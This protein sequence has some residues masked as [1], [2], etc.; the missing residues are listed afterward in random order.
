MP[1]SDLWDR[2]AAP[3]QLPTPQMSTCTRCA[4]P[5]TRGVPNRGPRASRPM[6]GANSS[7]FDDFWLHRTAIDQIRSLVPACAHAPSLTKR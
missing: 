2:Y 6:L 3:S 5:D 4:V 7:V 1:H